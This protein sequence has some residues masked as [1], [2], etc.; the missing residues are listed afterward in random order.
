LTS[1]ATMNV[2][3][4]PERFGHGVPWDTLAELR[5][6]APVF[7]YEPGNC[8]VVTTHALVSQVNRDVERFSS[9]SGIAGRND[10]GRPA[11][12][13]LVEMDPPEHTKYRSLVNKAFSPKSIAELRQSTRRI[14]R[15]VIDEFLTAGGGDLVR[16]LALPLPFRVM[17]DLVGVPWSDCAQV[18]AWANATASSADPVYRPDDAAVAT[19]RAAYTQYCHDVVAAHRARPGDGVLDYLIAYEVDGWRLPDADLANFVEVLLTGGSETTRHLLSH[20]VLLL[21]ADDGQRRRLVDGQVDLRDA[22]AELLRYT[23]PVMQHSRTA[24]RDA[25]VGGVQVRAGDRLTLWMVSGNRDDAA[26]DHPDDLDLGRTRN[27]YLSF[28][29]GG[30]HYCLGSHLTQLE[31]ALFLEEFGSRL[32]DVRLVGPVERV[33]SNFFNGIRS[34]PI[35]VR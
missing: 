11:R 29:S 34:A 27:R 13:V 18:S 19:A 2:D 4:T 28:G 32:N 12:R 1:V 21:A 9:A 15:G 25:E 20:T 24:T 26:F 14:V 8:W 30:P 23:S 31:A 10:P 5:R 33:W 7:W 6:A 35:E 3:L 22:V 17:A 16:D